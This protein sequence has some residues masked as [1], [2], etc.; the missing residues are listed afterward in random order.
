ML[1]KHLKSLILIIPTLTIGLWEYV[2][3]AFFLPYI[4]MELG[5]WLAPLI[6]YFVTMTLL[7]KLFAL[8]EQLHEELQQEK[9][10]KAVLEE[11]EKMAKELHD[12]I[13]QSLFLL[14]VR[15]DK[16]APSFVSTS[17]SSASS[18]EAYPSLRKTVRE[19]N[20][21]VR[22][23]IANLRYP[24]NVES[25]PW[26][27]SVT[28]LIRDFCEDTG[29]LVNMDWKLIIERREARTILEIRKGDRYESDTNSSCR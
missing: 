8:M 14:S 19:V 20:E 17:P 12:G 18:S 28:R 3:H 9:A 11:R 21:Y 13:A 5:N 7:R 15:V 16:L 26:L 25:E 24:A 1:Y 22:Q 27:S 29:I 2:R 4:S 6:V 10:G 23:A